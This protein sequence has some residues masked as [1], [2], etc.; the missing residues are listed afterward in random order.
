LLTDAFLKP[1]AINRAAAEADLAKA[2]RAIADHKGLAE[3]GEYEELA[4]E[5]DWARAR[6]EAAKA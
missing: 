4:R 6:V 5:L 3:G 2:E 1:S